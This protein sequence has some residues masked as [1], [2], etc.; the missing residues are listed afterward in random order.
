MTRG[1]KR[2][3]G[4][5][6]IT[7]S[8]KCQSRFLCAWLQTFLLI[9]K[10]NRTNHL[11]HIKHSRVIAPLYDPGLYRII[12]VHNSHPAVTRLLERQVKWMVIIYVNLFWWQW[13]Q[14]VPFPVFQW[15]IPCGS[16][17]SSRPIFSLTWST[18]WFW[19]FEHLLHTYLKQ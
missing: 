5:E 14:D 9:Q 3:T 13:E 7:Q 12:S 11:A 4:G 16:K 6:Y 19:L 18:E 2:S 8:G 17:T 15:Q 1:A 10:G